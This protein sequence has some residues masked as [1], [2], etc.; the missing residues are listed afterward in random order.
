MERRFNSQEGRQIAGNIKARHET[1]LMLVVSGIVLCIAF[2]TAWG[3][4]PSE[5]SAPLAFQA[6]KTG[7]ATPA[8]IQLNGDD[9][10]TS[11]DM[12]L[13]SKKLV[14]LFKIRTQERAYKPGMERRSDLREDERIEKTVFVKADRS[15]KLEEVTKVVETVEDAGSKPVLLPIETEARVD[16]M[17]VSGPNPLTLFVRIRQPNSPPSSDV[18]VPSF[19]DF[20]RSRRFPIVLLS[21]G[22]PI[23]L[24]SADSGQSLAVITIQRDGEYTLGE[25]RLEKAALGKEI[26]DRFNAKPESD[27]IVFIKAAPDISYGSLEDIYQAAFAAGAKRI[28]LDIGKQTIAWDEQGM[29]FT[30]PAGWR[31]HRIDSETFDLGGPDGARLRVDIL[32]RQGDVLPDVKNGYE[33]LLQAQKDGA[34]EEV[35]ILEADG[36]KGLLSRWSGG[37][38]DPDSTHLRWQAFRKR[39]G[40][41]QYIQINISISIDCF[42]RRK[43]ELYGILNSIKLVQ[44]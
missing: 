9:M 24:S 8:K 10:G 27:K 20:R 22:I 42:N 25:K 19:S 43:G 4:R 23:V 38:F 39:K 29:R 16:W 36:V 3:Q 34:Y 31:K 6:Q 28:D 33:D 1:G 12:S 44:G 41:V 14:E 5:A 40:K 15:I 35:R 17:G 18:S 32:D 21:G 7:P 2:V 13:L 26:R 37:E 11:N 30:L